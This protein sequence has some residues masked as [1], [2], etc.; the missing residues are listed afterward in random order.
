MADYQFN[1]N[2]N[3]EEGVNENQ[4]Q[5]LVR[6]SSDSVPREKSVS[7]SDHYGRNN[8][9]G[10]GAAA[11]GGGGGGGG[12]AAK[13]GFT[14]PKIIALVAAIFTLV[15]L[16]LSIYCTL[17]WWDWPW[18]LTAPALALVIVALVFAFVFKGHDEA[19][20]VCA[21]IGI[22]LALAAIIWCA[23]ELAWCN[24][25][26]GQLFSKD[27]EKVVTEVIK[28]KPNKFEIMKLKHQNGH[29][30]KGRCYDWSNRK[31]R[32]TM[33]MDCNRKVE[34]W[35]LGKYLDKM[36]HCKRSAYEGVDSYSESPIYQSHE[37]I[38]K[39]NKVQYGKGKILGATADS[40]RKD[41]LKEICDNFDDAKKFAKKIKKCEKKL[42]EKYAP[43]CY[44]KYGGFLFAKGEPGKNDVWEKIKKS[45][46]CKMKVDDDKVS[47]HKETKYYKLLRPEDKMNPFFETK[48]PRKELD[49]E[50][51]KN[52]D[53]NRLESCEL[54]ATI[55]FSGKK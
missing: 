11:G 31:E 26:Q 51:N 9:D 25:Y 19:V 38:V 40:A 29:I 50:P 48:P 22:I 8:D 4:G 12:G 13:S 54:A 23:V 16:G 3:Q 5:G 17:L 43:K 36:K 10:G 52:H 39:A 42:K 46:A 18:V 53:N 49:A 37:D 45:D 1:F 32:L 6:S 21:A 28:I 7:S 33:E 47:V 14:I 27:V 41:K 24:S 35:Y 2:Q 34:K 44:E 15:A 30:C 20:L 55:S